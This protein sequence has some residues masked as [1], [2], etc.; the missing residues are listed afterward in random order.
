M[1]STP[2]A[3]RL[4]PGQRFADRYE[5]QSSLGEGGMGAV[6]Q[7]V[8]LA[9]GDVVALK[10]LAPQNGIS[11]T[12]VLRFRQEV[13]LARRVTHPNVVRVYDIGEHDGHIYLTMELVGGSTLSA[14]LRSRRLTVPEAAA[15]GAAVC[16]GLAA[17]HAAGV[18][19]RDLK[20]SN[21]LISDSGRVVLT[22]FG[23]A[24]SLDESSDFTQEGVI[25]GTMRYM[26]PE[27]LHRKPLDARVDVYAA[28]VVLHQMLAG[29]VP[30][31][32]DAGRLVDLRRAGV[33]ASPDE[34]A[35][36]QA[37]LVRCL[38]TD[39]ACRFADAAE[40]GKALLAVTSAHAIPPAPVPCSQHATRDVTTVHEPRTSLRKGASPTAGHALTGPIAVLPFQYVGPPESAYLG[41]TIADELVDT[42]AQIRGLKVLGT[43]A[44]APF[45]QTRDPT[46]IGASLGAAMVLDGTVQLGAGGRTRMIVRLLDAATGVQRWS[47]R[48]D[49]AVAD[50]FSFQASIARVL[51]ERLRVELTVI[52]YEGEAPPEA[53]ERYLAARRDFRALDS[54]AV[55]TALQG[56]ERCLELAPAFLP[57]VSGH[58]MA[59]T[60]AWFFD[61]GM[62]TDLDWETRAR[63]SVAR[64]LAEAPDLAETHLA[65]AMLAVQELDFAGAR[66]AL[67]RALAIAPTYVEALEYLGMLLFEAGRVDAGFE[68]LVLVVELDPTRPYPLVHIARAHALNGNFDEALAMYARAE[69]LQAHA[70]FA[71]ALG[72]L[73]L[74]GWR[75]DPASLV[76]PEKVLA[77]LETPRWKLVRV[78]LGALRGQLT[79]ADALPLTAS[80]ITAKQSPRA[81]SSVAQLVAEI[82]LLLDRTDRAFAELDR[83][84]KAGLL[85]I[86]WLDRCPLLEPLRAMPGFAEVRRQTFLRAEAM[87]G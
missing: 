24:Q 33:T 32:T 70:G 21:I 10:I 37:L 15:I 9:L 49:G 83:G 67:D 35:A 79:Q 18:V 11:P 5:V 73:R 60:R 42:L 50:L 68:K 66:R 29:D 63:R 74:A 45:V 34:L 61:R 6:Y 17:A 36:W 62:I 40:L 75:R 43:G 84:C 4:A 78:Y 55:L 76:L 72:R 16:E 19:H 38:E 12:A 3:A 69:Q 47:A 1:T 8:D 64:A 71:V 25:V 26:A 30:E 13:R 52:S 2:S 23:I 87:G 20:P 51:A 77:E 59:T 41:R 53:V 22:D 58:A 82:W 80:L 14:L 39:P 81:L 54:G 57:A 85:D 28:G 7:A 65:A 56:F 46:A 86:L 44:C 27:Q 31:R 48:H